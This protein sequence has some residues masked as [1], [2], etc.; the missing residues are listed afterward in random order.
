MYD[1]YLISMGNPF[2][3]KNPSQIIHCPESCLA[4]CD[5]PVDYV[6]LSS[7]ISKWTY[8][9]NFNVML[10]MGCNNNDNVLCD[11]SIAF[12]VPLARN[13]SFR[14]K[15]TAKDMI[16]NLVMFHFKLFLFALLFDTRIHYRPIQLQWKWR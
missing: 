2:F 4:K 12:H 7:S 1:T 8:D 9:G 11:I 14:K 5:H 10:C 3:P 13:F 16:I 15:G 6:H